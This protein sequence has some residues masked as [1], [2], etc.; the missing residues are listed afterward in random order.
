[1]NL[2]SFTGPG[3]TPIRRR[4]WDEVTQA[5]IASRKVAGRFVSISEHPGKGTLIN[6]ADNRRPTPTPPPA[7]CPTSVTFNGVEFC[8]SCNPSVGAFS[9]Y[10]EDVDN[11]LNGV[12]IPV[13]TILGVCTYCQYDAG[14]V[15][16]LANNA[17]VSCPVTDPFETGLELT[18]EFTQSA[19]VWYV[20]LYLRPE[21]T[22][23]FYGTTTDT[24]MPIAN[25]LT[26]CGLT[27]TT[28]S[29][30]MVDCDPDNLGGEFCVAAKNGTATF[31]Y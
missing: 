1:M 19:S 6:V 4:F 12:P 22:I 11:Q 26:D 13:G 28:F 7:G 2:K 10:Y 31:N 20:M 5:V 15:V 30:P 9:E 29:N 8:C 17:G 14:G 3:S 24:S 27:P 18:L 16:H 23:I 25:L 21:A